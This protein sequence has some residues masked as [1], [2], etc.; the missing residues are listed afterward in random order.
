MRKKDHLALGRFLLEH[1]DHAGLQK[2]RYAFLIGCVEPDYNVATYVRGIRSHKKF[3]GHNTANSFAHVAKCMANFQ[4]DGLSNAWDYFT[5]GTMLHYVADA[6][7]WPHNE[8]W[9]GNLQQHVAYEME[10]HN[11]FSRELRTNDGSLTNATVFSLIQYFGISHEA[12]R[13]ASHRIETDCQYI[14]HV[15]EAM[16]LGTLRYATVTTH[17]EYTIK[18]VAS[19]E[20]AYH[21]GLV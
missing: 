13:T 5:L 8:F 17:E 3:R 6:F 12:Y 21:H 10:L 4:Y 14:I 20:G 11:A 19:Y 9:K 2:Y 18:E 15:C 16:L 7:T 1:C